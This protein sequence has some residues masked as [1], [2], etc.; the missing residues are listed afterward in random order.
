[1]LLRARSIKKKLSIVTF[2]YQRS[3][4]AV[5]DELKDRD[6]E[7]ELSWVCDESNNKHTRVPQEVKDEAET[8]AKQA[9]E[10]AMDR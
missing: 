4:Y 10:D 9:L 3:I 5:H 8:H 6:W 2:F 7:L 1:M